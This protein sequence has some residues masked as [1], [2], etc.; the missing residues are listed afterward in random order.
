MAAFSTLAAIGLAGGGGAI[1]S[2]LF[3]R[4]KKSP[5]EEPPVTAPAPTTP[6]GAP[7]SVSESGS[8]AAVAGLQ[9]AMRQRKRAAAG[10]PLGKRPTSAGLLLAPLQPKGL[11]G[12]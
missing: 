4:R 3:G 8:A 10:M 2:R 11:I 1:A 12:A 7:P 6:A 9:S 5:T